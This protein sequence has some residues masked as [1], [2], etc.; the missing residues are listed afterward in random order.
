MDGHKARLGFLKGQADVPDEFDGM[1]AD[2]IRALFERNASFASGVTPR[3]G[4]LL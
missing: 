3:S 1:S 4:P 2:M